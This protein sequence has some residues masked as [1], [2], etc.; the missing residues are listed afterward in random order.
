MDAFDDDEWGQRARRLRLDTL[1][2]LRWLASAGQTTA[3]LISHYGLGVELPLSASLVCVIASVLLNIWL[4]TRYPVSLRLD[5]RFAMRVL[6]FDILQLAVLLYLTGGLAHPFA[7]LLLAPV[8]TSAVSLPWRQTLYLLGLAL[9]SATLLEFWNWPLGAHGVQLQP[10]PLFRV[11]IWAAIGVT[12]IFVAIYANRVAEE[13][14]QLASALTATDLLLA[15]AQHLSQLDGLAAAAAHELGT[16]LATVAIVVHELAGQPGINAQTLEDLKLVE[17]QVARCRMILGKLSS[18]SEMAQAPITE[19]RLGH[20]IEEIAA[21]HRLQDVQIEVEI[22]GVGPE[23]ASRR[24]PAIL[25]GLG[26]LV[27]NAVGF[28]ATKVTV[29]ANWTDADIR[30]TV[31][32]DGPGFPTQVLAQIGEPYISDRA[33]ARRGEGE[34]AGGL[35]LGL[36]IA[37]AL[38]ERS[39]GQLRIANAFAPGRGARAAV[40]WSRADFEHGRRGGRARPEGVA[41][42]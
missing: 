12:A 27:E 38:L 18:P 7:M 29:T 30:I 32:D 36:F 2:R 4:R 23:P 5:D 33:G 19:D 21:P 20:L 34:A 1:V 25:Y 6:G 16:P 14:R 10:S 22:F 3:L 24:D 40:S 15:R 26:N 41:A 31:A 17:E 28:A 37:K 35:G 42:S 13:A 11:G 9:F 8:T 39:G